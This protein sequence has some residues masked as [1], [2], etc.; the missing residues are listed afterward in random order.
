MRKK[1]TYYIERKI[2]EN[3]ENSKFSG[4]DAEMMEKF[5]KILDK[6]LRDNNINQEDFCTKVGVSSGSLS[7]YRNGKMFPQGNIII[8]MAKELNCTTDYLLGV[9][10]LRSTDKNIKLVHELTGLSENSITYLKNELEKSKYEYSNYLESVQR[11]KDI[12]RKTGKKVKYLT[13]DGNIFNTLNYLIENDNK[14]CFFET[15]TAYLWENNKVGNH[16]QNIID[17]YKKTEPEA[18]NELPDYIQRTLHCHVQE[19][20]K[21]QS[22]YKVK[23]DKILL[24]IDKNIKIENNINNYL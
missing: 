11:A 15:L 4:E 22:I 1:S 3:V 19:A 7:H 24:E 16:I 6:E 2:E 13:Y 10:D 8:K 20:I 17:K 14:Y 21:N 9:T 23:L 12:F 18:K 5:S